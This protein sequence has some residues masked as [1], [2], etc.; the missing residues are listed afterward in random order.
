MLSEQITVTTTPTSIRDLI[1]TAR[2]VDATDIPDTCKGIMM[3]YGST[4]IKTVTLT[5]PDHG[6]GSNTGAV[7]LDMAGESLVST[8]FSQF[9]I[10]KAL[11]NCDTGTVVVHLI[12]LQTL[13]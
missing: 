1:A 5:D 3:R 11:L 13:R 7:I 12:I 8:S 6:G 9:S 10:G 4:E 2:G